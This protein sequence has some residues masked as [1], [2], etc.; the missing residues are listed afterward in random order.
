MPAPSRSDGLTLRSSRERLD[1][2]RGAVD[3][4]HADVQRAQHRDVE[5]DVG[6]I[7]VGDDGAVHRD[8]ERLL[9]ELR[10]VLQDAPQV[11]QFHFTI[12]LCAEG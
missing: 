12:L 5:Q 1:L 6:E 11:S 8:D 7:F 9:P 4:H 2:R 3:E 10:D